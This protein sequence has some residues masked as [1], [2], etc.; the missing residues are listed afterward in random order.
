MMIL[1]LHPSQNASAGIALVATPGNPQDDLCHL[2]VSTV[3]VDAV[4]ADDG[5]RSGFLRA[6]LSKGTGLIPYLTT[7]FAR[8]VDPDMVNSQGQG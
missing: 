5:A 3:V 6:C 4:A 2:D 7:R 8:L 1:Q